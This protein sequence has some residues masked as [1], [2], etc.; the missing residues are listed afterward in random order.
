MS[1]HASGSEED[2]ESNVHELH[3]VG[4]D[5]RSSMGMIAR[6]KADAKIAMWNLEGDIPWYLYS[7]PTRPLLS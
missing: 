5:D 7:E 2:G 6:V 1:L 3:D 4:V